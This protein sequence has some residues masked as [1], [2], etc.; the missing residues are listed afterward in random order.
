MLR[1]GGAWHFDTGLTPILQMLLVLPGTEHGQFGPPDW[2]EQG[3][4]PHFMV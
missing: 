4:E 2:R 3:Q 1:I